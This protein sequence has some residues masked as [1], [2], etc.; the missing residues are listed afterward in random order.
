MAESSQ[1]RRDAQK[2]YER[3]DYKG[4]LAVLKAILASGPSQGD[5]LAAL[6][7]RVSI[8][9][10]LDDKVSARKD[11]THM[12]RTNRADGRGY[13]R[14]GQLERLAA[15]HVAAIKWYEHGLKKIPEND[16]LHAFIIAQHAKTTAMLKAHTVAS[17]PVD[18]FT[19]LPA[20]INEMIVRFLT[21]REA[22]LCLRVSKT[23][24]HMLQTYSTLRNT[25]D[26]S[27]VGKD[28]L[29]TFAGIKAALR[30]S[31]KAQ[32]PILVIAK[33][34]T[35]PAARHLKE[36]MERWI[37]YTKMQ[38]FEVDHPLNGDHQASNVDFQFLQWHQFQL[39]TVFFG[40]GHAISLDSVY[41]ILWS[42]DALQ[43]AVFLSVKPAANNSEADYWMQS[44]AMSR[45]NLTSLTIQ[46]FSQIFV[47]DQH[48]PFSVPVCEVFCRVSAGLADITEG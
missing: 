13:L 8:F 15:D 45:P 19:K 23:W 24:R 9:L 37:H 11:A 44:T 39:R 6:D 18:P 27:Q 2:A 32:R 29:V 7:L 20:E 10:K 31:Q 22:V 38:H 16:R 17:K 4:A 5:L 33:N 47:G 25:L 12:I 35:L 3:R 36:T 28:K 34:L 48:R 41:K 1:L 42:C 14:L 30:R 26:F 40:S 21:Y 43:E 46:G